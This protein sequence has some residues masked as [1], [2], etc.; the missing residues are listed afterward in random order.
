[1]KKIFSLI[2]ILAL[3]IPFVACKK[4]E[5]E[6]GAPVT[7]IG[8]E[9]NPE[10]LERYT[11]GE[12]LARPHFGHYLVD[13]GYASCI[14]EAFDKYLLPDSPV[15]TCCYAER[16][17]PS[18]AEA[19]DVVHRA[20]GIAVMAHPKY[21]CRS[22]RKRGVDYAVAEKELFRLKEAG[23]D[24]LEAIYQANT[25]GENVDFI[26]LAEKVGLLKTAGSD[27]HGAAKPD[28]PFGMEVT[29]KYIAP[30]LEALNLV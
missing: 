5:A 7:Y 14:K 8:I 12:V 28:V 26:R 13:R 21:W 22:W 18:Q 24:G 16:V 27:F 3:C 19:I 20:G 17:R 2:L 25:P 15:A 29:Q 23:L 10:E 30:F 11:G 6:Q 9:I 4:P 1:M